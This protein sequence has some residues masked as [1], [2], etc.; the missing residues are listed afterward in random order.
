[1]CQ[2]KIN[3][4][5]HFYPDFVSLFHFIQSKCLLLV[6]SSSQLHPALWYDL[7]LFRTPIPLKQLGV[8][9]CFLW[10]TSNPLTQLRFPKIRVGRYVPSNRWGALGVWIGCQWKCAELPQMWRFPVHYS[11]VRDINTTISTWNETMAWMSTVHG[12]KSNGYVWE[13]KSTL[14]YL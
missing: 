3:R 10:K 14:G 11:G 2:C 8:L 12:N 1:M 9:N 5:P 13:N 4:L 6:S 7:H